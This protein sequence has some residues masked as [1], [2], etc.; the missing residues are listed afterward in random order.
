MA[1]DQR[2]T[3]LGVISLGLAVGAASAVFAFVLG[4]M[5]TLFGWGQEA[6]AALSSVFIGYGPGF[7]GAIA[8]AVWAFVA[9]LIFGCLIAA[10]Y[11]YFLL[12]RQRRMG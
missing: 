6:A 7:V 4:V 10:F 12:K 2:H 8:G 9:G 1:A 3:T 5:A 11:N